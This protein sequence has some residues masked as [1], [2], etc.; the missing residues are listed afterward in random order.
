M[1]V[2]DQVVYS[3]NHASTSTTYLFLIRCPYL[4]TVFL[5]YTIE[6]DYVCYTVLLFG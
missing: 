1:V 4:R 2:V 5:I 6:S 3:N